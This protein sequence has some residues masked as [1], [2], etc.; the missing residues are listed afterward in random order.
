MNVRITSLLWVLVMLFG[1]AEEVPPP[2]VQD[3]LDD[4]NSLE[5][6]VVRCAASRSEMR[7]APECVNA[8]QAVSIIEAR[9]ERERRKVFEAESGDRVLVYLRP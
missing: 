5:A 2:S 4:P 8:R 1:C 3:Y 7:Y 6:A 9:K